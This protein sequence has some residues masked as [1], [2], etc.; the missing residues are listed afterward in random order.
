MTTHV[1]Y[2]FNL[3]CCFKENAIIQFSHVESPPKD[4]R[5]RTVSVQSCLYILRQIFYPC[6][7][8]VLCKNKPARLSLGT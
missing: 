8:T 2:G 5:P 6:S 7:P 1:Q 4:H 3:V